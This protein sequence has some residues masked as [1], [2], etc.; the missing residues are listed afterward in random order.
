[1]NVLIVEDEPLIRLGL[2]AAIEDAGYGAVEAAHADEALG[3]LATAH[4]AVMVTDVDMPG[5]MNGIRLAHRVRQ[6]WPSV[7]ILVISGK[8]GV[9]PGELP[10]GVQFLSKPVEEARLIRVVDALSGKGNSV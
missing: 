3:R 4:F 8:V 6:T 5:S 10:E 2:A 1:M 9:A 7:Q